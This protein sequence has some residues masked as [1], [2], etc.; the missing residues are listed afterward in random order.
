M[1]DITDSD[2][3]NK[4]Q[5]NGQDIVF[6][7]GNGLKLDHEIEQYDS[8]TGQLVAW[9][10]VPFLS[11]T[12][13]PRIYVYYGNPNAENQQNPAAVWDSNF[14]MVQHLEEAF[15]SRLDSTANNNYGATLNGVSKIS[16]KIG[17]ADQFDGID[18]YINFENSPTLNPSSAV[19]VEIWMKLS[20]TSNYINLVNKGTY[21]QFYLRAGPSE[22][23][24]YWYVRFDDGSSRAIEG[25]IGWKWNTWHYLV[26]TVDTQAGS[27]KVYLDGVEKI[28]GTFAAGKTLMAT[29]NPVRVSDTTRMIKGAVDELRISNVARSAAWIQAC[30]NNQRDPTQFYTLGGEETIPEFPVVYAPSPPNN[31]INISP[32]ITE[33]SFNITDYQSDPMNYTVTTYPDIGSASGTNV[34]S[35]KISLKVTGLQYFTTYVWT[36]KVTDGEHW[37]N[38]TFTFT[39]LPSEPPTHDEPILIKSG[40][41]IICYNQ[42]TTDPDGD[43]VTNIYNWYRNDV[44]I[45]DLLLPFDTNSSTTVKDY[46]GYNNHG[47]IIR[48]VKWTPN[49]IIGG[50]YNFNRGYI[51][52]PGT[53]TLD[54]GGAW[55]EITV[56]AWIKLTAYP[57][58]GTNTRIIARIPSYEIGITSGGRLFASIWTATGNPKISGHNM[59]TT[60]TTLNLNTWYHIVLTYKKGS[61]MTLY[62]NGIAVA[63]KTA[64]ESPTLNYNIQPSGS[65]PLYIGWFDYFKGTID[66][67]RIYPRSLTPQQIQQR[68]NE[69]KDGQTNSS[70]IVAEELKT[71]EKW[72]CK[73]TP[74]DSHQDGTTKTSNTVTIGQND[75]PI[76]KN[77]KITPTTP[78]TTDDLTATYTYFDPDGDPESGTQ[79]YWYRNGQLVPELNNS[80]IVPSS[81]TTKGETW[82]FT[83]KPSDGTEYGETQTS[84]SVT[85][86]NSPPKIDSYFPETDP[87]INE[88]ESQMF[89]I[90]YSD[91]D[92]DP[93]TIQWYLNGTLVSTNDNYIFEANYTSA[94]KYNVK[95]VISDGQD[96]DSHEWIL[97]VLNVNRPPEITSWYPQDDP[98]PIP[99]GQ[100]QEFNITYYDP[101]NDPV[102]IQWYINGTLKEEW[103]NYTSIT[104]EPEQAGTYI[105][106][107]LVSDQQ[108][109]DTHSWTLIV[110]ENQ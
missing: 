104:F 28:S 52:I 66:E 85:I 79:I 16:G 18:D 12:T 106:E 36:I 77:L 49:G 48:D 68:Y 70:T 90:T 84:P 15:T 98:E 7:D 27:M 25:N 20:S 34:Q 39:T 31:A 64:T 91:N 69:T 71:G 38:I 105:I 102:T 17:A 109:I 50:A 40:G 95:V 80:L 82:Y 21:N 51:Q 10:K 11:S 101:D 26:A 61:E 30:Y 35:G 2:I 5:T 4:A 76:A 54:G 88:G 56:E 37:T 86:T 60:T 99:L 43:K 87:T 33:L 1:I 53:S 46:S 94:G 65:N 78:K 110:Q 23:Y 97:T 63:T 93:I 100:W 107:V 108:S 59:I 32:S 13:D 9:V 75:K 8:N 89:N 29:T 45:T 74:N 6:T 96:E 41:N 67:I 19:T 42:A 103:T 3:K 72:Y 22:G 14:I 73:I 92:N 57:P 44:S 24:T 58:S 55:T 62:I 83:V 47:T 81:Y